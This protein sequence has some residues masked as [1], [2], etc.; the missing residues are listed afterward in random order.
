[1]DPLS[2]GLALAGIGLYERFSNPVKQELEDH[3]THWWVIGA[4]GHGKTTY[5]RE[6]LIKR[7]KRDFPKSSL[8]FFETKEEENVNDLLN[9]LSSEDL[10][11][12]IVYAPTDMKKYGLWMGLNL[13]QKDGSFISEDT[14]LTDEMIACFERAFGDAIKSNSRDIMR[15]GALA[16]LEILDQ[17][18]LLEVYKMF[19]DKLGT[20]EDT[21]NGFKSGAPSIKDNPNPFRTEIVSRLRNPFLQNYF[22]TNF[23]YPNIRTMDIYNPIYNK[24]RSI[25]NDPIAS[26][27]LCQL[28]GLPLREL[29]NTG[30][31]I[32]FYFPKGDLGPETSRL[33]SSIA[34]SKIQL[35]VQSRS[36]MPRAQR[37][38]H[39]IMIVCDE[40]QDYAIHNT[41]FT[42]FL[43]QARAFGASL[44]LSHQHIHQVNENIINSIVGNVGNVVVGRI[45]K[46][47][48]HI[49]GPML[50]VAGRERREEII[51]GKT[52]IIPSEQPFD[53]TDLTNLDKFN[54]IE[55]LTIKGTK[56]FPKKIKIKQPSQQIIN[57]AQDIRVEVLRNFGIPISEVSKDIKDRLE[58]SDLGIYGRDEYAI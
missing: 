48:A 47:D 49:V 8:I 14:L 57:I 2:I 12:T 54:F 46:E 39:P 43:N 40:F 52:V 36:S 19:N 51:N 10:K 21:K 26:N 30:W 29:M 7:F 32:I 44:V 50:E 37:F 15:N 27:C 22:N 17:V 6:N 41:S 33:L 20:P 42:E 25:T 1:M 16:V 5:I 4:T 58:S 18:S 3:L 56:Q 11:R 23:I 55:R 35:G 13:L 31:N 53:T 28:N 45:S 24:F 9:S 34:F 38:R